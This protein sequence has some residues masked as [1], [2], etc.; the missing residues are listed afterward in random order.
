MRLFLATA[1]PDEVLCGVNERATSLRPRLPPASWVRPE[2]QHLTFAFLG[3]QPESLVEALDTPLASALGSV[4]AFEARLLGCGF[5]P[6]LRRARVGWVGLDPENPFLNV[7]QAVR[8]V[9]T[10]H[11]VRLDGDFKAHLTLMRMREGWPPAS[12]DLFT[13]SLRDYQ[14]TPFRVDSVTLFSSKLDP[15]GAVHTPLR[16]FG[17]GS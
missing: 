7:A 12:I 4:P 3:E 14:S 11:G 15:K 17:L 16:V 13:R 2:A 10:T 9:A 5:F 6:N 1:F 8:G